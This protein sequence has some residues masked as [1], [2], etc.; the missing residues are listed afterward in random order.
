MT[1]T[2]IA[3]LAGLS[4]GFWKDQDELSQLYLRSEPTIF[5]P[6][7]DSGKREEKRNKWKKALQALLSI[8]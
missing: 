8:G 3:Y 2:G 1:A 6:N 4:V 7:L 5:T